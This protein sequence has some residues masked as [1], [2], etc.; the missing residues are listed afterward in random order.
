MILVI[1]IRY[2]NAGFQDPVRCALSDSLWKTEEYNREKCDR[3]DTEHVKFSTSLC[4]H[5]PRVFIFLCLRMLQPGSVMER[6]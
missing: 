3:E 2:N 6:Y 4:D 1:R 5:F